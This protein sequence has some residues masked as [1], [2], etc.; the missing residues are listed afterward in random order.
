[1]IKFRFFVESIILFFKMIYG[2]KMKSR[3]QKLKIDGSM[4]KKGVHR[5]MEIQEI[6]SK[7]SL[8]DRILYLENKL[9]QKKS[10]NSTAVRR[11]QKRNGDHKTSSNTRRRSKVASAWL[12]FRLLGC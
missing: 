3:D 5:D 11:H 6:Q 12:N 4:K 8:F 1:M 10:Q 2:R 9:T 7:G